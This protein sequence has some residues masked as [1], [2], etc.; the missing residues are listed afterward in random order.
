MKKN[1]WKSTESFVVD[2]NHLPKR[3]T[4]NNS[5]IYIVRPF[6]FIMVEY[7]VDFLHNVRLRFV[8]NQHVDLVQLVM[9]QFHLVL[10]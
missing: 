1:P 8:H 5:V 2:L 9:N 6:G 10:L 3:K 4:G 7:L